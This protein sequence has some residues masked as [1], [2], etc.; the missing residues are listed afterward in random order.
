MFTVKL[1]LREQRLKCAELEQQLHEM[2]TEI[3]NSSVEVDHSLSNDFTSIL[4]GAQDMT[5][6]M[7]LFWQQQ[8]KLFASNSSGVRYHPMIICYCLSLAAKSPSCYEELRQSK[9][10]VLPSQRTLRDY[11]NYIRPTRG[12]QDSVVEELKALTDSYFD[13]QRYVVLLF[14]EMKVQANLVFEKNTGE[15]IGFVDLGDPDVNFGTLE[16]QDEIATH[17][18]VFLVH[19]SQI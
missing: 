16:K 14:D 15:L 10:L 5:P 4:G 11:R 18:L 13:V 12:F 8:K 1:T 19:L 2:R 3:M 9:I 6:F 17:A 7:N